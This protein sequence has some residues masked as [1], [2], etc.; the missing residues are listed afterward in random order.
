M[1]KKQKPKTLAETL[2]EAFDSLTS[3]GEDILLPLSVSSDTV[4]EK[5]EHSG[6]AK[7]VS[8]LHRFDF[9]DFFISLVYTP[10]RSMLTAAP[11]ILEARICLDKT[12]PLFFLTPYDVIPYI[13]S[14]DLICRY[15]SY[16]ESPERL[17]SCYRDLA[18]SLVPYLADFGRI[19]A[20]SEETSKAYRNLRSEMMRCYGNDI[21][22]ASGKGEEY[23]NTLTS[24]RF[25]HFVK[26]KS[27]FYCSSEYNDFLCGNYASLSLLAT[28]KQLPD[29]VRHLTLAAPALTA[30]PIVAVRPGSASLSHMVTTSKKATAL[31]VLLLTFLVSFPIVAGLIALLYFGVAFIVG[32]GAAY[33]TALSLSGLLRNFSFLLLAALLITPSFLPLTRRLFFKECHEAYRPYREMA[34]HNPVSSLPLTVKKVLVFLSVVLVTVSACSGVAFRSDAVAVQQ[35]FPFGTTQKVSYNEILCVARHERPNESFYYV[36]HL[37]DGSTVSLNE[38]MTALHC[39]KAAQKLAPIFESNGIAVVS[40]EEAKTL[41]EEKSSAETSAEDTNA[42]ATPDAEETA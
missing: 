18:E 31:P 19:A 33:F 11:S 24:L 26:W 15:F 27:S 30:N 5:D 34:K 2:C 40:P 28:R 8:H 37:K 42:P 17:K 3:L 6:K 20:S 4:S 41:T 12:E 16:I 29:F 32:G 38:E 9:G 7:A 1:A 39:E 23:D 36:L 22:F 35:S 25:Y 21:F 13:N 10:N 14:S